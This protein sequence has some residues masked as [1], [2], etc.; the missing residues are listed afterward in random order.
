MSFPTKIRCKIKDN[1]NLA[2]Y[3]GSCHSIVSSKRYEYILI[4]YT[5]YI[6]RKE[7]IDLLIDKFREI[8]FNIELHSALD[9]DNWIKITNEYNPNIMVDKYYLFAYE[10]FRLI[11]KNKRLGSLIMENHGKYSK[12][13]IWDL[14]YFLHQ[15]YLS[16]EGTEYFTKNNPVWD[17]YY[18]PFPNAF[19]EY[20]P[21]NYIKGI[22]KDKSISIQSIWDICNEIQFDDNKIINDKLETQV[23]YNISSK[24]FIFISNQ[25]YKTKDFIK[26][27]SKNEWFKIN[28]LY[29]YNDENK[30]SYID[31]KEKHGNLYKDIK[32]KKSTRIP[33][34]FVQ[35]HNTSIILEDNE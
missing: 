14:T 10:L 18:D 7:L 11:V 33:K 16:K 29:K 19:I 2:K 28:S 3:Y 17:T 30:V 22:L 20:K 5:E 35:I 27:H 34:R 9:I 25:I 1:T 8:D 26:W 12:M 6:K 32:T 21:I 15:K 31:L 24:I 23:K 13:N 4:D